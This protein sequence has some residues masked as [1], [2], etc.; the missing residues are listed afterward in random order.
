MILQRLDAIVSAP[1][2]SQFT[3]LK[4]DV[5][6]HWDMTPTVRT[7]QQNVDRIC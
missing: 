3:A 4:D 1:D 5:K 2:F 7:F 6:Q